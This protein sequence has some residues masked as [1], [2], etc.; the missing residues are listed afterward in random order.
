MKLN[1]QQLNNLSPFVKEL[2]T[3]CEDI[4]TLT[5]IL[6]TVATYCCD[7]FDDIMKAVSEIEAIERCNREGFNSH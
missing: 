7:E 6:R 3:D 1:P 2:L 5:N 4:S